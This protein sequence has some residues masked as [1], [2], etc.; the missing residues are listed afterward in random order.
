MEENSDVCVVFETLY[1]DELVSF[2]TVGPMALSGGIVWKLALV[3]VHC[4][5]LCC[6][7][8]HLK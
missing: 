1:C 2:M 4:L 6:F 5:L 3:V 7:I 8:G